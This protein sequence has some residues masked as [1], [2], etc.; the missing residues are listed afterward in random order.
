VKFEIVGEIRDVETI[1]SGCGIRI[2]RRLNRLF[3]AGNLLLMSSFTGLKRTASE[4]VE[5]RSS[6]SLNSMAKPSS[7]PFA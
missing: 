1:A 2:F 6:V 4:S 5:S 3:G 7:S